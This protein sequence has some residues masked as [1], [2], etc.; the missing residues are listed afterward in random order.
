MTD[1]TLHLLNNIP[2]NL[3]KD[4]IFNSMKIKNNSEYANELSDLM[5]LALTLIKP[6]AAFRQ[7]RITERNGDRVSV[8]SVEFESHILAKILSTVETTFV[9]VAT[10]G[11]EL[12][13]MAIPR[14]EFLK[15]FCLDTIKEKALEAAVDYLFAFIKQ[16]YNLTK[17]PSMSPGSA[18]GNV[19]RIE[20]QKPLFSLLGDTKKLI[21]VELTKSCLMIPNKSVSGLCYSTGVE[22]VSCQLCMRENCHERKARFNPELKAEYES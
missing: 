9:F 5:D 12:E 21:G 7:C 1:K 8:N 18:D 16:K 14:D 10:C 3:E 15:W 11:S 17:L 19:W 2:F 6:K 20:Q 4:G 13:N 22:L